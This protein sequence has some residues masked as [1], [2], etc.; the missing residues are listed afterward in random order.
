M[1]DDLDERDRLDRLSNRII[2]AALRVHRELG[3]GMLEG[4]YEACLMFELLDA[5]LTV[6]REK[7]LPLTYRGQRLDCGYRLDLLVESSIIV[8]VKTVEHLD[9]VH[10]AQLLSYLKATNLKL[11]LLINFNVKWLRDGVKRIVNGLPEPIVSSR[12][13]R[14]LR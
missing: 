9:A 14:P 4:A 3:P 2:G 1:T 13:L 6:E 7:A 11:G 5:G 12:P 8:E 10:H